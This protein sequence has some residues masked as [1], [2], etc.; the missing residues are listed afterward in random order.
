MKGTEIMK[1]YD[2]HVHART[3]GFDPQGLLQTMETAGVFGG[4][5]ISAPPSEHAI[6][7]LGGGLPFEERLAA[8]LNAAKRNEDRI[9]PILWV[10]P[11]EENVI[12]KVRIAAKAGIAGFKMIC[13]G[14]Y[15]YEEAS[16]RLLREIASL[17]LPVLFHT[18]ILWDG[19]VS[20]QYNRPLNWESLLEIDG[21][22]FSMGHCSWP[23][24][25][26]CIALYGKFLNA[27][28]AG[29][30][31]EMFFDITPGTP[32]I[33]RRELLT[34]LYTVGYDVGDN[35]MFGLDSMADDWKS[36]WAKQWLRIDGEILDELGVSLAYR[37]KLYADNLLRFLGKRSGE[38]ELA[39]PETDDA[40]E[41]SATNP[42]VRTIIQKWYTRLPFPREYDR[43]FYEA[44]ES[45]RVSDAVNCNDYD[46]KCTD[47]KRNLLSF[48][49]MCEAY[50]K[51]CTE[52]GIPETVILDTLSD[53]AI[54]C[55]NWSNIKG[56]LYLGELTWLIRHLRMRLFRLGRLQFC[57]G[58][59]EQDIEKYHVKKG[60][61]VLEV[62]IPQG[63]KL[64]MEACR[65]S[66]Q[67]A[68]DFFATYFP[69]YPYSVFTCHSWM[70]DETLRAYL[71]KESGILRFGD[72][73]DR[74][75]ADESTALLSY[76]FAFDTTPLNVKYR[77][78]CTSFASRIQ[79]AV[80]SGEQFY[81]T[82]GVIPK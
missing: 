65:A 1:I 67:A 35:V 21:I 68:K 80:L 36:E 33:Y 37:Q 24:I 23:W 34:K 25:D 77:Y 28:R 50:E 57:M 19:Q 12:E 44:L 22:R 14:Y 17:G 13:S 7:I 6:D 2:M 41:W 18:G 4:C 15:V 74:V 3:D 72:L 64:S 54:W 42:T 70:L 55:T 61:T 26:E 66:M 73:F 9:F 78:P 69:D 82:L 16:M 76:L 52:R 45:I 53:I 11:H 56:E 39:A 30:R 58:K 40:H 5:V 63:E 49:F 60:D 47:G 27:R 38:A 71:P 31:V 51:R 59:A 46:L 81:E 48:L 10:H 43:Q 75:S 62:H 8:V 20:S 79:K 29:K 32:K